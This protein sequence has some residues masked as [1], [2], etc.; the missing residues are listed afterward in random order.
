VKAAVQ[1]LTTTSYAVLGLL[2]VRSWTTYE[3]AQQ[4]S[5]SGQYWLRSRSKLFEEPKKL[6]ALGLATATASATGNRPRTVYS[7]TDWG[8]EALAAWLAAPADPPMLESE[9]LLKVFFAEHGTRA[10]LLATIE[11]LGAWAREELTRNAVRARQ[12]LAGLG[13]FPERAAILTLVGRFNTDFAATVLHWADWAAGVVRDWP[14]DLSAA[15]PDRAL[16]ERLAA[17]APTD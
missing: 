12:Y 17:T 1:K 16:L 4:V 5:S 7:I 15:R 11:A 2:A 3:L 9:Q 6:A 13:E 10:D 14:D 8:R